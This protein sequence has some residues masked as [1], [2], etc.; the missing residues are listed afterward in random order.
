MAM[1]D[2]LRI[3]ICDPNE[4]TR[5]SL[6]RIILGIDG[7]C[8]EADCGRYEFFSDVVQQTAPDAVIISLDADRVRGTEL[9]GKVSHA[10]P[11]CGIVAVCNSSDGQMILNAV[12]AGA[13]EFVSSPVEIQD[14]VAAFNRM[15][16][17]NNGSGRAKAGSIIAVAGAS[18]G[19]GTTSIAVNLACGIAAIPGK[20][21]VLVDLDLSLGDADVFLDTIPEYTLIDVAQNIAR[22]DLS[23]LR[24][25][26]TKHDSGVYLLPRPVQLQDIE[27]ISTAD[28]SRVLKLLQAS[29]THVVVDLSKSYNALDIATLQAA[30]QIVL[31]TQLD[32]PCLRNVVRLLMSLDSLEGVKDKIRIVINRAGLDSGQIS[33]KKA[34]QTIQKEIFWQVPNNYQLM[35]DCRNN[36]VP[37]L[38]SSPKTA[39]TQAL[40]E[41]A[42]R[43][44]N[45]DEPNPK[46]HVAET[47]EKRSLFSFLSKSQT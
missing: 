46:E 32:L 24:K 8:L 21:V 35:A 13:R 2:T 20:T 33:L 28:F 4:Q 43:L 39:I 29:F 31:L 30:S 26:L 34:E 12:R 6:K 38:A 10:L 16:N 41:L 47:K 45:G 27:T 5:E 1:S 17:R 44:A 7:Y 37:L 15:S 22:L 25:S 40:R 18:G 19:V 3:A 14:L 42:E 9:I 36:G 11:G 23:L